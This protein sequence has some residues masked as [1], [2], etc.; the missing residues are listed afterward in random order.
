MHIYRGYRFEGLPVLIIWT[1]F[2]VLAL[3]FEEEAR[4]LHAWA[5]LL[6]M[7][8]VTGLCVASG[9]ILYRIHAGS[10]PHLD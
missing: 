6:L 7:A 5:F 2:F 4:K 10:K 3:M 9:Y 1:A 8:L